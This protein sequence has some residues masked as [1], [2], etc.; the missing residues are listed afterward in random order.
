MAACRPSV[1]LSAKNK[2]GAVFFFNIFY[3][4]DFRQ[5]VAPGSTDHAPG[6]PLSWYIIINKIQGIKLIFFYI[7]GLIVSGHPFPLMSLNKVWW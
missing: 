6:S 4:I 2:Q 7:Q 1:S 3:L 5:N